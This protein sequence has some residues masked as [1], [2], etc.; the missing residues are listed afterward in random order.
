LDICEEIP[1]KV[2]I[3]P[4]LSEIVQGRLEVSRIRNVEIE[5]LLGREPVHLDEEN[6]NRFLAGKTVM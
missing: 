3:I 6:M 4:A 5:D 2:R 1:V